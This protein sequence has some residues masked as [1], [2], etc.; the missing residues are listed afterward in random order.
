MESARSKKEKEEV[1]PSSTARFMYAYIDVWIGTRH[2][3]DRPQA[4]APGTRGGTRPMSSVST[5][6]DMSVPVVLGVGC[7]FEF[8]FVGVDRFD[9]MTPMDGVRTHT[10][11][12]THIHMHAAHV[13]CLTLTYRSTEHGSSTSTTGESRVG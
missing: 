2:T 13:S 10:D 7:W 9:G 3:H 12:F 11:I 4:A 5:S 1:F 6:G 8:E